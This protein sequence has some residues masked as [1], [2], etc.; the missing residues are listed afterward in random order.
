MKINDSLSINVAR[1]LHTESTIVHD[2]LIGFKNLAQI[3]E[4][5]ACSI[6]QVLS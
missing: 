2:A 4:G 1:G 6:L 5:H 3:H